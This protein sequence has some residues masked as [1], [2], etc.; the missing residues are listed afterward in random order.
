MNTL[1]KINKAKYEVVEEILDKISELYQI[2]KNN[3]KEEILEE[4]ILYI[5][6]KHLHKSDYTDMYTRNW[7]PRIIKNTIN[8]NNLKDILS[9]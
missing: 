6:E 9:K 2:E 1:T 7:K 5:K 4:I 8:N 3:E